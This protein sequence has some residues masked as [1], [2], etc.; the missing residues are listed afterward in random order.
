MK[1]NIDRRRRL[2]TQ[3]PLFL[4]IALLCAHT[5]F[6]QKYTKYVNPFIGSSN[7][8]ATNPG[9]ILPEGMVSVTPFNV[10]KAPGNRINID[11]GWCSA[12][13]IYENK[14]LTGFTH[15]NLSGVGCPDLGSIL[16]MP[17]TGELQVFHGEYGTTYSDEQAAPGYYAANLDKYNIK[18]EMTATVRSGLSRYTFPAGQSHILLNLGLGLTNEPGSYAK[19]VSDTEI[20]GFKMNGSFCYTSDQSVF[21]VY[22]VVRFSKPADKKGFFKKIPDMP[23]TR[24]EWYQHTGKYKVY[25]EYQKE[26]AGDDLGVFFSYQTEKDEVIEVQVGVSY[27]SIENARA[28]LNAEQQGF[29]FAQVKKEAETAWE[30]QLSR[31]EVEGGSNEDKTVFYTALYHSLIHPNIFQDVNGEYSAA[32]QSYVGK[33]TSGTRYNV[34]SMWDTYRWYGQLM[35]LVYPERQLNIVRSL[36]DF[37][38]ES[39]H[40]PKWELASRNFD[41]MEG[42]P[43]LPTIADTWLRGLNDFDKELAYEAMIRQ[44]TRPGAE[45]PVRHDNDFY[46][47]NGYVPF[48]KKFDNSVSQALEYYAADYSL[49]QLAKALGKQSDYEMLMKRVEGYKKYFDPEYGLLRP[50]K[51]NGEFME[52]FDP[53]QGENFEPANGFHEGTSW[54]YSF[55]IPFDMEGLIKLHGGKKNFVSRLV[56]SFEDSLFDVTNEPDM[57]YPYYFNYIKGEEWRTQAYVRSLV[58]NDF[59]ASPGGIPGNDDTGTLSTWVM[60]SMMGIFPTCPGEPTFTLTSPVFDKVT[61]HLDEKY[62]PKKELVIETSNNNEGNI[63]I[64]KVELGSKRLRGSFISQEELLKAGKLMFYLSDK[65]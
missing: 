40:L 5:S 12:P 15:V 13:Y 62:F 60:W 53:L 28:N 29:A 47:K 8:G 9:A 27:V 4:L 21:P 58:K 35:T 34:F 18:A 50:V 49:A 52:N 38:K 3:F 56:R 64:D 44:A 61:I 57:G 2:G 36:L 43:A 16:L 11:E 41:V 30:Q 10:S 33:N 39:G 1:R 6:S 26:L 42:D 63:Y 31:I 65:K 20:E 32:N 23:G 25:K 48:T 17:T 14:V 51:E 59:N 24:G 22:F 46:S 55:Y 37:Y 7:F 54:N 45:N 19:I